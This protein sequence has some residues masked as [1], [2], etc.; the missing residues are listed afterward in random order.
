MLHKH[1]LFSQQLLDMLK[2]YTGFEINDVTGMLMDKQNCY[3][4]ILF[5]GNLLYC[6][7]NVSQKLMKICNVYRLYLRL[8]MLTCKATF[9][10]SLLVKFLQI[11]H[12]DAFSIGMALTDHEMVDIHYNKMASLQVHIIVFS[13][14]GLI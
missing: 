4:M 3:L 1:P 9:M 12:F 14:S 7:V 10:P 11:F 6:V 13:I 2:F 5:H 8:W